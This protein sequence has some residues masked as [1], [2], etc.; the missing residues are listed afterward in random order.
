MPISVFTADLSNPLHQTATVELLDM[1]CRDDFGDCKPLSEQARANLI[2]GLVKHGGAR[3]F[4][5]YDGDQPLG[6][7]ICMLGFSSFRGKPLINIHDVAVSPAARGQ[8]IGRKLLA[9]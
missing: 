3:V 9:A 6:V 7:A 1:Y 4:L 8:G 5:A 2:P